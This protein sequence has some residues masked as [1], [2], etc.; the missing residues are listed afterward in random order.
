MLR[1]KVAIVGGSGSGK[2]TILKLLLRWYDPCEGSVCI[3]GQDL[4]NVS[5]TS[6]RKQIGLVPQDTVLFDESMIYNLMY[7]N[8]N[9]SEAAALEVLSVLF[10]CCY[11]EVRRLCWISEGSAIVCLM[12]DPASY[13]EHSPTMHH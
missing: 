13:L 3:D 9:S 2:S 4:R 12:R 1:S 7:G 5:L 8:L 11:R 6:L 10:V